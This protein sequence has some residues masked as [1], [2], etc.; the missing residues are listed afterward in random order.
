MVCRD[1]RSRRRRSESRSPADRKRR[2][3]RSPSQGAGASQT[4]T[5]SPKHLLAVYIMRNQQKYWLSPDASNHALEHPLMSLGSL[6]KYNILVFCCRWKREERKALAEHVSCSKGFSKE[7]KEG[8]QATHREG[9]RIKKAASLIDAGLCCAMDVLCHLNS[10]AVSTTC[11]A[12]ST[13]CYLNTGNFLSM[14]PESN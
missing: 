9:Q 4:T 11:R 5:A 6:P 10:L 13:R 8:Q 3:S 2:R 12:S 1:E 7:L 14:G